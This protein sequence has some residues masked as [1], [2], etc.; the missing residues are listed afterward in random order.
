MYRGGRGWGRGYRGG[1]G[2]GPAGYYHAQFTDVSEQTL[3]ENEIRI[4]KDQL[5]ALEKRL[6]KLKNA[7]D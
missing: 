7:G 1:Y 4:L 5:T 2:P 6:S 3:V